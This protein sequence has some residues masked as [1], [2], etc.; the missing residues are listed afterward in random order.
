MAE[1]IVEPRQEYP[2]DIDV[3]GQV[4]AIVRT[5]A[6][7]GALS[8]DETLCSFTSLLLAGMNTMAARDTRLT[9]AHRVMDHPA[10]RDR[11]L[12]PVPR[13]TDIK[14]ARSILPRW[15]PILDIPSMAIP[16]IML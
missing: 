8:G 1:Q 4:D 6:W 16:A 14:I 11:L 15:V 7:I 9:L 10:T 12:T 5:A 3:S 13:A 2:I